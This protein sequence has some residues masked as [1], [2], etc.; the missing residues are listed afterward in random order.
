MLLF[1]FFNFFLSFLLNLWFVLSFLSPVI[2][3]F[4][5]FIWKRNVPPC[6]INN[7]IFNLVIYALISVKCDSNTL[8]RKMKQKQIGRHLLLT[9]VTK[10]HSNGCWD[11]DVCHTS[12]SLPDVPLYS[13]QSARDVWKD[14]EN[15]RENRMEQLPVDAPV[16]LFVTPLALSRDLFTAM[17]TYGQPSPGLSPLPTQPP[18]PPTHTRLLRRL[19]SITL[20]QALHLPMNFD[21]WIA[22]YSRKNNKTYLPRC[23]NMMLITYNEY[24]VY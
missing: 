23:R 8:V 2:S 7:A 11:A 12:Q 16:R 13:V 18:L 21:E 10:G 6:K 3:S 9:T 1:F 4:P 5:K 14:W 20:L 17:E 15:R 22:V 19:L 24:K